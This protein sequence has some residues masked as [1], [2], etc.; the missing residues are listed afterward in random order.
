MTYPG[1]FPIA[2]ATYDY[3]NPENLYGDDPLPDDLQAYLDIVAQ[4]IIDYEPVLIFVKR[5]DC[6]GCP[7]NFDIHQMLVGNDFISDHM[8]DYTIV[9]DANLEAFVVYQR[10]S[11]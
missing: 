9:P 4:D 11:Q 7:P 2:F 1:S 3:P 10:I 8:V 6:Y 5:N